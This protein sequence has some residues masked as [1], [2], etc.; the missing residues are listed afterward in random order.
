M[1][2]ILDDAQPVIAPFAFLPLPSLIFLL[3]LASFSFIGVI[4]PSMDFSLQRVWM[5]QSDIDQGC[6]HKVAQRIAS[7]A[8]GNRTS[9]LS[10]WMLDPVHVSR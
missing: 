9:R 1:C 3:I 5:A 8:A 10:D 7:Q 4:L 2:T 6:A